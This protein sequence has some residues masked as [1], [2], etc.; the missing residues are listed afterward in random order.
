MLRASC[1]HGCAPSCVSVLLSNPQHSTLWEGRVETFVVHVGVLP[2]LAGPRH[3]HFHSI[4]CILSHLP[5]SVDVYGPATPHST[6]N[7][8]TDH[9]ASGETEADC[10][11]KCHSPLV[12]PQDSSWGSHH[13]CP[14]VPLVFLSFLFSCEAKVLIGSCCLWGRLAESWGS[15]RSLPAA[16]MICQ[17]GNR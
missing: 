2:R 9:C 16:G 3:Q 8:A 4:L 11:R 5:L 10:R 14:E 13:S 17:Q 6:C 15:A 12:R 7:E 1:D